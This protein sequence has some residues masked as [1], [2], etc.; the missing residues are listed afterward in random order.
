VQLHHVPCKTITSSPGVFL[1]LFWNRIFGDVAQVSYGPD[2]LPLTQPAVIKHWGNIL[3][4]PT[5][6]TGNK[7][8]IPM[9]MALWSWPKPLPEFTW[10]I[11]WMQTEH[12]MAANRQSKPTDLGCESADKWLLPSTSTIAICYYYSARK[13]ILILPSHGGWKAWIDLGTAGRVRR[14]CP[15]LYI[16]V[17]VVIIITARGL[18]H[19]SQSCHH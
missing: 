14:P 8:N 3:I 17:T 4:W 13:V 15:G 11:W 7:V 18:S 2:V 16:A 10:F 9:F 12:Q 19:R 5:D 6:V 1:H